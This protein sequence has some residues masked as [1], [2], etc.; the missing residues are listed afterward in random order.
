MKT[1]ILE[2]SVVAL[3]SN[4][5]LQHQEMSFKNEV[6]FWPLG[7]NQRLSRTCV[8]FHD[9]FFSEAPLRVKRV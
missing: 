5:E 8:P 9:H 6:W 1:P 4:Q 2:P 3:V 7:P